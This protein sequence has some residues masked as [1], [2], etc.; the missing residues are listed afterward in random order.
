MG[1]SEI[2]SIVL[3][4]VS[5][6]L[7]VYAVYQSRRYKKIE[8]RLDRD[9][10]QII[11]AIRDYLIYSSVEIRRIHETISDP[12]KML[13]LHKDML[14]VYKTSKYKSCNASEVIDKLNRELSNISKQ[15]YIDSIMASLNLEDEDTEKVGVVTLRHQYEKA[16][17]D[18]I[19]ELNDIFDEDGILFEFSMR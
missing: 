14:Y 11:E 18:K 12:L 6:L 1:I 17:L 2:I 16:D 9:R 8:D 5:V 13:N 3:G 10:D 15:T 7:G 19:R 4:I